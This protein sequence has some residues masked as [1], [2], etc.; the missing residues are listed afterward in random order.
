MVWMQVPQ[1]FSVG[2]VVA[3]EFW[4]PNE[5]SVSVLSIKP[6]VHQNVTCACSM[7]VPSSQGRC[8]ARC[9]GSGKH[10]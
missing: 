9:M 5:I 8:M 4:I 3:Y 10:T 1:M 7:Q 2:L 6:D